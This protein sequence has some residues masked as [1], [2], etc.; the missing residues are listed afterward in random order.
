[1]TKDR[2]NST[3]R[4]R[5]KNWAMVRMLVSCWWAALGIMGRIAGRV[6]GMRISIAGVR[7]RI[8]VR[9]LLRGYRV[10]TS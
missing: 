5:A 8:S 6:R 9:S 2:K 1:M 10:V 7:I 3:R 4:T